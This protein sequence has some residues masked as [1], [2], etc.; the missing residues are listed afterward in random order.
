MTNM[1][2]LVKKGVP[3]SD[4]IA[5]LYDTDTENDTKTYR[6][7]DLNATISRLFTVSTFIKK[8]D[9][10]SEVILA[11]LSA[12]YVTDIITDFERKKLGSWLTVIRQMTDNRTS[13]DGIRIVRLDERGYEVDPFDDDDK[14][15]GV[16]ILITYKR[17]GY[18][19]DR[20]FLI[21]KDT[22]FVYLNYRKIYTLADLGIER[23]DFIDG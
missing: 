13:I 16:Y 11:W 15:D 1:E 18:R 4:L 21:D 3:V 6:I 20:Y 23:E 8:F 2:W 9:S 7:Y 5:T 17:C 19:Q 22:E 14:V 10:P 12:E